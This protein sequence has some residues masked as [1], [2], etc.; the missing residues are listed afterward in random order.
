M[1][2]AD[3]SRVEERVKRERVETPIPRGLQPAPEAVFR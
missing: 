1:E 2:F 3:L